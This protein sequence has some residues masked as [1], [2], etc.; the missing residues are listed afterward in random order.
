MMEILEDG[1]LTGTLVEVEDVEDNE[2]VHI[3]I[4]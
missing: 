3:Y 4:D 2:R 1:E